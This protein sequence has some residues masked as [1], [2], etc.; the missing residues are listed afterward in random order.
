MQAAISTV[1]HWLERM[2]RTLPISGSMAALARW[3]S[4]TQP[5][6]ISSG[7]LRSRSLELGRAACRR[8]GAARPPW[9]RSG[10]ISLGEMV[11]S[12]SSAGTEQQ[13]GDEEHGARREKIAAG[14]HRGRRQPV[15]DG[16]EA[17]IA[18]EPLAD[19]RV[20]D[21][22]EADRRH[23]R[24][25]HATCQ[26]VQHRGR[27]HDREDRQRRIGERADA[28]RRRP[29]RRRPAV[30]SGRH[31]PAR[32]PASARPARRGRPPTAPGRYRPASIFAR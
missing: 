1:A 19:R 27:Q 12:A 10:S 31:R 24:A 21:Q 7:R 8:A 2:V 20:S 14:A 13:R 26:R 16:G 30:P 5:A 22:A 25:E 11:R 9:A 3:N 23:G 18:A 6:K 28:D 32:R 29:R 4:M 17:G 15:A